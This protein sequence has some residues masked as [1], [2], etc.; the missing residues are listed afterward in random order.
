MRKLYSLLLCLTL[1]ACS[2]TPLHGMKGVQVVASPNHDFRRPNLVVL[3]HTGSSNSASALKVLTSSAQKV[4]AHYLISR[5]GKITQLVDERNRAWHAGVS[6]WRNI[7]DINS[8]SIGIELDNNG[9]EPYTQA[10]IASLLLLLQDL[11]TRYRL[12]PADFVGHADVAPG[13]KVDPASNFPWEYLASKG[14]GL[15]CKQ[16][17]PQAYPGFDLA[18]ALV[19]IGYD[20]SRYDAARSSFAL[21]FANGKQLSVQD[22]KNLAYCLTSQSLI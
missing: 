5:N 3:H 6:K 11:K 10:Q 13:R 22:E 9:S 8:T 12:S 1:A 20:V 2:S 4:S 17:W 16:P 21:H 15:W 19:N 18:S 7:T 14:F